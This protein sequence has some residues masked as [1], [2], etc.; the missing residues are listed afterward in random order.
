[1]AG[2]TARFSGGPRC[3]RRW[4]SPS[5]RSCSPRRWIASSSSTAAGSRGY[6]FD[7]GDL[8]AVGPLL[9]AIEVDVG[10]IDVYIANTGGPPAG[11]PLEFTREQWEAAQ[12]TLLVSPME[13]IRRLLPGMRERGFGR[14]V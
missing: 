6:G 8:D 1:M 11:D 14:I 2:W 10:P 7:S 3:C 9:D 12:A 4:R 13:I 5:R